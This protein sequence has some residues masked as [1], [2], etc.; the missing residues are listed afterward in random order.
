MNI[1]VF[2]DLHLNAQ[3]LQEFSYQIPKVCNDRNIDVLVIA[4]DISDNVY[5]TI[6][7][8]KYLNLKVKTLYVP[9]NH[10]MWS[11]STILRTNHIY[12]M[13]YADENCL[14]N[15]SYKLTNDYELVGHIGW[16]DY[17]FGNRD[18]YSTT[19]FDK[20]T[21]DG[22]M[23]N[24][25]KYTNLSNSNQMICFRY[26]RQ[27]ERLVKANSR[28][29]ILVTHMVSNP[30]FKVSVDSKRNHIDYFNAFLGSDDLYQI[31]KH[32]NVKYAVCGHVH[33]R[34]MVKENGTKYICSCLGTKNEW[35]N[36]LT[37]D[38]VY[39]QLND[40]IETITI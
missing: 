7:F 29:K 40:A 27:I 21:I 23:W 5:T 14:L 22:R 38:D 8:I 1:G 36:Y 11:K 3:N 39:A 34:K 15:K 2:S 10:D 4:G 20:M 31:T 6:E 9:G 30:Q 16:Y 35:H 37:T 26:N 25:Y 19:D 12:N 17:S 18:L 32:Q 28:N 33:Y 24:D 13:Y